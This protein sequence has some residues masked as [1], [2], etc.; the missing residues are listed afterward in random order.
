[1]KSREK[2]ALK[3]GGKGEILARSIF[4]IILSTLAISLSAAPLFAA[5]KK[6]ADVATAKI[7]PVKVAVPQSA[8]LKTQTP[9]LKA[10]TIYPVN[11]NKNF[12]A[13]KF[14][15]KF[16]F[17]P[18]INTGAKFTT[19]STPKIPVVKIS[20]PLKI[21]TPG[22]PKIQN[23][24]SN[25]VQFKPISNL[26][27]KPVAIS[28][29]LISAPKLAQPAVKITPEIKIITPIKAIAPKLTL[30]I[31]EAK[32]PEVQIKMPQVSLINSGLRSNI[33]KVTTVNN[34]LPV[35]P[36][37]PLKTITAPISPKIIT[38]AINLI[39]PKTNTG[40]PLAPKVLTPPVN[41]PKA[42]GLKSNEKIK[43]T[44]LTP[45]KI[46]APKAAP[47]ITSKNKNPGNQMGSLKLIAL[48]KPTLASRPYTLKFP[49]QPKQ[50]PVYPSQQGQPAS[51]PVAPS[52]PN[53]PAGQTAG[54]NNAAGNT[55]Q[56]S[57]SGN[58]TPSPDFN[59][60]IMLGLFGHFP[61]SFKQKFGKVISEISRR[62]KNGIGL[63]FSA[64]APNIIQMD[65]C[66]LA[67]VHPSER[68]ENRAQLISFRNFFVFD[69][70]PQSSSGLFYFM[71]KDGREKI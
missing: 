31:P 59:G 33:P 55:N 51:L 68:E 37:T 60:I 5:D 58:N 70:S 40:I 49:Q 67:F 32:I 16:T 10:P 34:N 2:K 50:L 12:F 46:S 21:A 7:T 61:I 52:A 23:I 29:R 6:D 43:T 71:G 30:V 63:I 13:P 38:P 20:A 42:G 39:A 54:G 26:V 44:N 1:M 14:A 15:S 64:R 62:Q 53:N 69:R 36:I 27:I 65:E 3:I 57:A 56:H 17:A 24:N 18:I 9:T 25:A 45:V 28:N 4:I 19:V 47:L 35:V 41:I 8:N 66:I 22:V 11:L 48:N